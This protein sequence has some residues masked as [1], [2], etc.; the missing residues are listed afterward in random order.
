MATRQEWEAKMMELVK[1][2]TEQVL[3]LSDRVSTLEH[4]KRVRK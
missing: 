3:Y 2:L 4:G 1:T